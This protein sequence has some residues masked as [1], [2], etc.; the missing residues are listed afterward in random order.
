MWDIYRPLLA[1]FWGF[2]LVR[3]SSFPLS[4]ITVHQVL[5]RSLQAPSTNTQFCPFR[6]LK[7]ARIT[8][9]VPTLLP[10]G[11]TL[12]IRVRTGA[13]TGRRCPR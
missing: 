2:S 3:F 6:F 4:E 1:P 5:I 11:T 9:K 7:R 8:W 13:G 10:R 12:G